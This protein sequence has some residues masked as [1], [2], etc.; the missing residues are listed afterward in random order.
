M[1][2]QKVDLVSN[3]K[4]TSNN[5]INNT[6]KIEYSNPIKTNILYNPQNYMIPFLGRKSSSMP[7]D[8]EQNNIS[9]C[10]PV[11]EKGRHTKKLSGI[12]ST[13]LSY[14]QPNRL[15]VLGSSNRKESVDFINEVFKSDIFTGDEDL[16]QIIFVEDDRILDEPI[17]FYTDT[18]NGLIYAIGDAIIEEKE[19]KYR[20]HIH[21]NEKTLIAIDNDSILFPNTDLQPISLAEYPYRGDL[22]NIK[23]FDIEEVLEDGFEKTG[24][25]IA[26][27]FSA[28]EHP[29][30]VY[31]PGNYP[32]FKDI[33]GN[34]EAIQRV[35]EDIYAPMAF[36]D[37]FGHQ[38]N[39]GTILEGPSGTGKSM[40]GI[41]LCN[42][43]SK[44]LG[45]RV[46]MQTISGAAMQNPAVGGSEAAWRE[47]F[48]KAIRNQPAIIVIDEM[49]ACTQK[50]DGSS[51]ARFD[52]A[53]V[54]QLL[55]LLSDL[56]KSDHMVRIIG[57]TNRIDAIDPA[58]LR[59]G[60]FG[61]VISVPAPNYDE[62]TEIYQ[63]I[64]APY[65]ISPDFDVDKFI[66]HIVK[67]KGTGSTIAITLENAQKFARRKK[68]IYTDLLED[69]RAKS[70]IKKDADNVVITDAD[71]YK[72]LS[73]E[74]EKLK[75]ANINSD[76]IVIKGFRQ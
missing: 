50:R 11:N 17:M 22:K 48:D 63:K 72:A 71:V 25:I 62:A 46:H 18:E 19:T 34:K 64:S 54:N 61:N 70:E 49:D 7:F 51:N 4:Y 76:R 9:E 3:A 5:R 42:E 39:K 57:M 65:N 20:E 74:E 27:R 45:Q 44:R 47:A 52:N 8:L 75:K 68:N 30:H 53:V 66:K 24:N 15:V 59:G 31:T 29:E 2:I 23:C 69:K 26:D 36:P 38:M 6:P 60:R 32:M 41:A 16:N 73:T 40:L 12:V 21:K 14:I 55:T 13:A 43:L 33:G 35:I 58:M 10:N 28:A 67:I 1:K 37:I 56:E